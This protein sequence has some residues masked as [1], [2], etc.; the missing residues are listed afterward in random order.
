MFNA[1]PD[2]VKIVMNLQ[3]KGKEKQT[4]IFLLQERQIMVYIILSFIYILC[5]LKKISPTSFSIEKQLPAAEK[6]WLAP[7]V[8]L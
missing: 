2:V 7:A 5:T 8:T 4:G 1:I 3:E 6:G